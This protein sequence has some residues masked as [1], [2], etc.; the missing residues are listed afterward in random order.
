[1]DDTKEENR[2]QSQGSDQPSSADKTN[3]QTVARTV[4]IIASSAA[5][6]VAGSTS[7]GREGGKRHTSS[8]RSG[9]SGDKHSETAVAAK[10]RKKAAHKRKLRAS[11]TKG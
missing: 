3:M 6:V 1:M 2:E 4:G 8:G 10:K 11:H 5:K 9:V 7:A